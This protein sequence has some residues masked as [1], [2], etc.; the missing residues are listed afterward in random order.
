[1][2]ETA[3]TTSP[4]LTV[5]TGP[6]TGEAVLSARWIG[7]TRTSPWLITKRRDTTFE[8]TGPV[9][10]L[11]AICRLSNGVKK[12]SAVGPDRLAANP[13]VPA[14]KL[15]IAVTAAELTA[16]EESRETESGSSKN[17]I[18]C[19]ARP[20]GPYL[21]LQNPRAEVSAEASKTRVKPWPKA[22]LC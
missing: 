19:G 3:G 14:P 21:I 11:K 17:F 9:V 18:E 7:S 5:V 13:C 2:G 10:K 4:R 20:C 6:A 15:L 8:G 22:A 1:M 12:I 16:A